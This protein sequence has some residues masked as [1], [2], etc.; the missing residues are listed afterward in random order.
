[1]EIEKII[2][3]KIE[4]NRKGEKGIKEGKE[5]IE[6]IVVYLKIYIMIEIWREGEVKGI[7]NDEFR[8]KIVKYGIGCN[9][10]GRMV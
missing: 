5:R 2:N 1:M 6:G 7:S 4:R 3:K 10:R 8:R 9:D